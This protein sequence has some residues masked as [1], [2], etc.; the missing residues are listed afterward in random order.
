MK[1]G[2]KSDVTPQYVKDFK[3]LEWN[4]QS[5]FYE[6]LEMVIQY[7]FITI[8]VCAFP[9]A[10]FFAFLN[11]I[12][13]LRLDAKKVLVHYRRPIAQ[14]V[15]GIGVWLDIIET[16][17]RIS[18]IT[19]AFII[20]LTSEFIPKMVYRGFYSPDGSLHG[21]VN[22]SLSYMDMAHYDP[23]SSLHPDIVNM[24][25]NITCRYADYKS[26]ADDDNP[27]DH[28]STFWHIWLARLLFVVVFENTLSLFLMFLKFLIPDVSS[29]LKYRIR[30]E[31]YITKE[32]IIRT[33]RLKTSVRIRSG[34]LSDSRP[35][36]RRQS[37]VPLRRG[38]EDVTVSSRETP[39]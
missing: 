15:Q 38:M 14:K 3:L 1:K 37:S 29:S 26:P 30:R 31:E 6:Y 32:I 17:G 28:N 12:L 24:D 13:E 22:F 2:D 27:Y 10:P 23:A 20:A 34:T 35:Q 36:L 9:L 25:E 18:I 21:Y 33:E 5:L 4:N 7:G 39:D 16:L 11:N 8:F 19:N